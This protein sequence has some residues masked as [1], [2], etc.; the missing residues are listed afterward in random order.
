MR[1]SEP[2]VRFLLGLIFSLAVAAVVGLGADAV[3]AHPRRRL[4]RL[5]RRRLDLVAAQRHRRYRSLCARQC[6][7]LRRVAHRIRR[8]HRVFRGRP[9]TAESPAR[10]PLRRDREREDAAGAVLDADAVRRR[11]AAR[12]A[13][14]STV[15]ASPARR[16]IRKTDGIFRHFDRAARAHRKLAADR[17]GRA[18]CAGAAPLRHA[19]RG[20][21]AHR[22]RNADAGGR[23]RDIAH[24]PLA[25][26]DGRRRGA[27]RDR[28]SLRPCSRCRAPRRRTP[29]RGS[30]RISPV[31]AFVACRIPRPSARRC[32]SWIRPSPRPCAAMIF[33]AAR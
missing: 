22:A 12:S 31:N 2:I 7:A 15:T 29:M 26:L 20:R 13:M 19:G 6:R 25:A 24:D 28:A 17:R 16:V 3:H 4:R 5:H 30:R 14:R 27:R 11:R 9:M 1:K 10:R 21:D 8:R 33:P 18:L 23:R 32:R